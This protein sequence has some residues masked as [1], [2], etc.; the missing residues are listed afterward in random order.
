[1]SAFCLCMFTACDSDDNNLLPILTS[2]VMLLHS[3]LLAMERPTVR[4]L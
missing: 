3:E 4:K 1:M 2:K